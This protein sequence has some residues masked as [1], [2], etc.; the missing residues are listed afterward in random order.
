MG[1]ED[2]AK[3]AVASLGDVLQHDAGLPD[4]KRGGRLVEDEHA[5]PEVDGAG[6]RHALPLAA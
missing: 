1:D 4:A 5:G 6:D 2:D 3:A